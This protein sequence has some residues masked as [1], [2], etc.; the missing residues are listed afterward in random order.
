MTSAILQNS[1]LP[2]QISGCSLWLDGADPNATGVPPANGSSVSTWRD[3]SS[4]A[5]NFTGSAT[6]TLDSVYNKYGLSFDGT[7]NYFI[8]AN[9]SLYSITNT[10]YCI[11][12]VHRFTTNGSPTVAYEVYRTYV[13]NPGSFF[14]QVNG[15]V[16]W[17]TDLDPA[18]Y[19][20]VTASGAANSGI[21]CINSLTTTTV[22]A[23]L[24]GTSVGSAAKG[25][26]TNF[27]FAI[28]ES[29]AGNNERL[30]GVIFEMIIYN[31]TLTTAQRQQVEG[32]LAQKWGLQ[33]S[34]PSNHPYRYSA[35]F[36]NQAYVSTIVSP[37]VTNRFTN[38]SFLPTTIPGC[39]LWLDAADSTTV[40]MSGT[41]VISWS[42]KSGN[43]YTVIQSPLTSG[44][45]TKSAQNNLSVIAMNSQVMTIS[46]FAWTAF[47]TMFFVI[48]TPSWFYSAG[49][50]TYNGYV[51][52]FNYF[53]YNVLNNGATFSD[54]VLPL[55]TQ[56]IPTNQWCIFSIGYGGG[57]QATNYGVNGTL[58]STTTVTPI[59]NNT[60]IAPLWLN[61]RWDST[62]GENVIIA[63]MLHYNT[64]LSTAQRQ[65]VEGY[66]AWK[67]G[68]VANLP[69][70]H[71]YKKTSAV[72][73]TQP[74]TLA[75]L[76]ANPYNNT[77]VF[78]YFNPMSIAGSVLWLDGAD[79]TSIQTSGSSVTQ[80]RDKSGS[81]NNVTPYSGPAITLGNL[82]NKSVI[83]FGTGS[84]YTPAFTWSTSYTMIFVAFVS[85]GDLIFNTSTGGGSIY[86]DYVYTGNGT[87]FN[88][89]NSST[90]SI[91]LAGTD[92][93]IPLGTT[94]I[95]RGS[96]FIL[97][98][99]YN[100]TG[101]VAVNY[102]INGTVRSTSV[103]SGSGGSW[104]NPPLPL[105]I[106]GNYGG[107]SFGTTQI[108]EVIHY[109]VSITSGQ[110]QQL[111]GYLAWKW[112]IQANLPA[113]HPY[114]TYP[115]PP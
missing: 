98:I 3:K 77:L 83:N 110:R 93:V 35:Y 50:S 55:G 99:G 85:A 97:S 51:A 69:S 34:L 65:Q 20:T 114:K 105:Y 90:N 42:D 112:G 94:V 102:A 40:G 58:R 22:N 100:S 76:G 74:T 13:P 82:N 63:E 68:I 8:Q 56:V 80:W 103:Y 96:W 60:A 81:G 75:V 9:G 16:Q 39:Q 101:T 18:G 7:N 37:T 45:I 53:L 46:S 4:T 11:F 62:S 84:M 41:R 28:G 43:G 78:R 6:Y 5:N 61:G 23:Y 10:S 52:S 59:G 106:S 64:S 73:A 104:A 27:T 48:N 31:T 66:L 19:I 14:R 71:P 115:P 70:D 57:T 107:Y 12:T 26:S 29:Q 24:N 47:A 87:L 21:G 15:A 36:T 30:V 86:G 113:T 33:T 2:T 88:L 1:F 17:I 108:A 95:S 111:E 54:S 38:A 92:S 109:N 49:S 44:S 79:T 89:N 32:Y 91:V 25:S 72:F 67:W